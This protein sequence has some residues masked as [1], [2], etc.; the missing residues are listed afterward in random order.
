[1]RLPRAFVPDYFFRIDMAFACGDSRAC[2]VDLLQGVLICDHL[3]S[4]T[5]PRFT[6]VPVPNECSFNLKHRR[7][8]HTQEFRTAGL[9]GGAI[10]FVS[11]QGYNEALSFEDVKLATWTLPLGLK[12]RW[13]PGGTP[14]RV[15]DLLDSFHER[16]LPRVVKPSFPVITHQQG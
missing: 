8:P 11:L 9:V 4:R 15:E 3:G 16:N 7:R 13:V 6:F 2:W 14:L 1:M 12:E 5:D 10:K